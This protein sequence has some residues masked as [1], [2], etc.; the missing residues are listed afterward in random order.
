[1]HHQAS[2]LQVLQIHVAYS[3]QERETKE[4]FL[5]VTGKRTKILVRQKV[6]LSILLL[7]AS[8]PFFPHC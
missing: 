6:S 2:R 5:D 8:G 3:D 4:S 7:E 1:M